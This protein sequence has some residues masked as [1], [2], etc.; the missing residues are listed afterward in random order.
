MWHSLK[1]KKKVSQIMNVEN[2]KKKN[3][4][5]CFILDFGGLEE[6]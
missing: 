5:Q 4:I 1:K 3:K 2:K 6:S